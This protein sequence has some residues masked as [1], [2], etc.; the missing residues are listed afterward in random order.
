LAYVKE[1]L[2]HSDVTTTMIYAH[3]AM[4]HLRDSLY[5]LDSFMEN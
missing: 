3:T 1:I 5:R 4:D 2:G